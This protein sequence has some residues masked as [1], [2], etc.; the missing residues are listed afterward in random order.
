MEIKTS[1]LILRPMSMEY[2][3]STHKYAS[4]LE[5]TRY[6][7]FLPN[8]TLEE[9]IGY[10]GDAEE[11]WKK[12]EPEYYEYAL[13]K[14]GAHI[15]AVGLYLDEKRET[16]EFGW[17][18]DKDYWGQGYTFEAASALR[19]YAARELGIRHFV[20]QC[21]SENRG[22]YRVMEKLGMKNTGCTGGRRNKASEE[23]RKELT[24]ELWM[25]EI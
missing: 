22:S 15:G 9:T 7:L 16:A 23:E 24:Y 13:I 20:A 1:R 21:D 5:N 3:E 14:D 25:D 4:D 18:L 6:M 2:L 19:D 12:E 11:E 8:N 10:L 17:I